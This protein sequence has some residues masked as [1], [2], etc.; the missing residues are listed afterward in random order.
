MFSSIAGWEG[1][2]DHRLKKTL[3][4]RLHPLNVKD[5]YYKVRKLEH[6]LR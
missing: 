6:S 2:G 4:W 5:A 1:R 3:P